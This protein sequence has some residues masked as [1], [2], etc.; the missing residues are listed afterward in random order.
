MKK[1]FLSLAL[2]CMAVFSAQAANEIYT[3]YNS[4]TKVLTYYY[5]GQRAS[6]AGTT[7]VYDQAN[8]GAYRFIAYSTAIQKVVID[9]SMKNAPL[10][11]MCN[12]FS[13]GETTSAP[14]YAYYMTNLTSIEG[15]ENLNTANVTDMSKMFVMTKLTS[16]DIST[17]DF[18]SVTN[19]RAMF[20]G[21]SALTTIYCNAS[22]SAKSAITNSDNMFGGCSLLVGEYGTTYDS[23]HKNISYAKPDAGTWNPGYF[24]RNC[25]VVTDLQIYNITTTSATFSWT[26]SANNDKWIVIGTDADGSNLWDA[27]VSATTYTKDGL[28][29]GTEYKVNI[30][31]VCDDVHTDYGYT[32]Y[33]TLELCPTPDLWVVASKTTS[34]SLTIGV[35]STSGSYWNIRY[36]KSSAANWTLGGGSSNEM[37]ISGLEPNTEYLIQAQTSCGSGNESE[38]T[39]SVSHTTLDETAVEDIMLDELKSNKIVNDGQ[40]YILRNGKL[41][42]AVGAEVK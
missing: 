19:T 10:T 29:P 35:Q 3:E 32:S 13:G 39:G 11:T 28:T 20:Y 14:Y 7:E 33:S 8:P 18:S 5:D 36:K 31:S 4:S 37:L 42:N 27:E 26:A 30:Q 22:L 34:T 24:T 23:S 12:F 9:A 17:F 15:L 2:L 6:R 38:W 1:V 25:P 40:L 16:I 41:Y 21:N